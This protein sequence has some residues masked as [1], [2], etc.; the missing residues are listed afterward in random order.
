M[1][2]MHLIELSDT[3]WCPRAVRHAVTD[4]S[5]FVT[6][7]T[8]AYHPIAPLLAGALQRAGARRVLDLGSGAGGPWLRLQP[9]LREHGADVTVCLTDYCRPRSAR[10]GA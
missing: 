7:M 2:R 1:R 10:A 8:G 9:L 4:F 3:A 5:R 6:E